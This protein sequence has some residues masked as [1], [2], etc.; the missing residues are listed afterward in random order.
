METTRE[1]GFYIVQHN[2][3]DKREVAQWHMMQYW[4]F[5]DSRHHF[6]DSDCRY[7]SKEPIDLGPPKATT[8]DEWQQEELK[9]YAFPG[10]MMGMN[11][12]TEQLIPILG[13]TTR[14]YF[15]AKIMQG[16]VAGF[17]PE[18]KANGCYIPESGYELL[19]ESAVQMADA[20]LKALETKT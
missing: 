15:S 14:E 5:S 8:Y 10:H 1:P 18:S 6:S 11:G 17:D 19:A 7:I 20:L 12:E 16:I 13:M 2:V 9:K 4:T 3:R